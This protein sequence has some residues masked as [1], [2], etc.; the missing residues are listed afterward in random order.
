MF[1]CFSAVFNWFLLFLCDLIQ[2]LNLIFANLKVSLSDYFYYPIFM[3]IQIY[4]FQ[5]KESNME[6]LLLLFSECCFS[7]F[8]DMLFNDSFN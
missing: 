2:N 8:S 6:C 7:K 5:I 4:S 3:Y 1:W